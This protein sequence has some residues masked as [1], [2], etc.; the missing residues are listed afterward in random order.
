MR[1]AAIPG[2]D[3][4]SYQPHALHT[5]AAAWPETNCYIDMWIEVLHAL[6]SRPGRD[7]PFQLPGRF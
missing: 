1:A 3:P 7:A 6:T 4:T 2:L 5:E